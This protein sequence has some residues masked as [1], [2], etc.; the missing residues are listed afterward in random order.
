MG[1]GECEANALRSFRH[2]TDVYTFKQSIRVTLQ[3]G[4]VIDAVY[5][6]KKDLEYIWLLD[7]LSLSW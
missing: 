3:L 5:V 1:S 2:L 7:N 6:A 4:R